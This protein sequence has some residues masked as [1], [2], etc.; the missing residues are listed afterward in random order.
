MR[1]TISK[2]IWDHIFNVEGFLFPRSIRKSVVAVL[3]T[4]VATTSVAAGEAAKTMGLTVS[5]RRMR[6]R[7]RHR[8]GTKSAP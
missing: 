4:I 5:L 2:S 6:R 8:T 3:A 7:W 1:A